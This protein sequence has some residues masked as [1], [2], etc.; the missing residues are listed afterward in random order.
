VIDTE[1]FE[2]ETI[3]LL[4]GRP[5]SVAVT[6]DGKQ[7]YV[8][9]LTQIWVFDVETLE[10]LGS[11]TAGGGSGLAPSPDGRLI[12]ATQGSSLHVIDT[13][14]RTLVGTCD[15]GKDSSL[16]LAVSPDGFRV[17]VLCTTPYPE[18]AGT[19]WMFLPDATGGTG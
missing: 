17:F 3:P 15:I 19:L 4:G 2:Q 11:I 8:G 1:T 5:A 10:Q 14:T 16:G 18:Q 7:L 6:P 9:S 12:F 13:A